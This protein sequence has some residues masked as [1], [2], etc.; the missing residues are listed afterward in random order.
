MSLRG[1]K[2]GIATFACDRCE[3]EATTKLRGPATPG[4]N[5]VTV[6][7][8]MPDGWRDTNS[9]TLC[10]VCVQQLV[11]FLGD[12]RSLPKPAKAGKQ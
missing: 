2:H 8:V 3:R 11:E 10:D 7:A 5:Y 4:E 9:R 6:H 12:N 1:F